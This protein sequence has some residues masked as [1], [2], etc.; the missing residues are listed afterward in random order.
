MYIDSEVWFQDC[1]SYSAYA[2]DFFWFSILSFPLFFL[3]VRER[4]TN[5]KMARIIKEKIGEKKNKLFNTPN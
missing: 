1:S 5:K 4:Q 3:D 2:I